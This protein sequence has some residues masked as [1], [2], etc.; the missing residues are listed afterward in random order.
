MSALNHF[1]RKNT[2]ALTHFSQKITSALKH[3]FVSLQPKNNI[4]YV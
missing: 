3:F 2:S 1:L 4:N